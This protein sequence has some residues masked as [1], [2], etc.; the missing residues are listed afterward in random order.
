[1]LTPFFSLL[2]VALLVLWVAPLFPFLYVLVR[3]RAAGRAEP[4]LGSYGLVLFFASGAVLVGA[5]AIALLVYGWIGDEVDDDTKRAMWGLLGAAGTFLV[6][7]IFVG[8]AVAPAEAVDAAS[9]I[10]GGFLMAVAGFVV[11]ASLAVL[12]VALTMEVEGERASE[13]RMEMMQAAGSFL[14]VFGALYALPVG[15]M[16]S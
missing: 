16:R 14:G 1:V 7:Q 12:F 11:F 3:W 4:G 6:V 5:A 15:R 9:R 13:N 10:F 2:P 8:R